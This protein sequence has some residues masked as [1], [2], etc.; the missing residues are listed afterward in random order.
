MDFLISF[1]NGQEGAITVSINKT[2]PVI[3]RLI[4]TPLSALES[5]IPQKV[6][7]LEAAVS[8]A[9]D[10]D[11]QQR[12]KYILAQ[13]ILY[14]YI[15]I[16]VMPE[17]SKIY[18]DFLRDG[19]SELRNNA[20]DTQDMQLQQLLNSVLDPIKGFTNLDVPLLEKLIRRLRPEETNPNLTH[21]ITIVLFMYTKTKGLTS[22]GPVVI[23]KVTLELIEGFDQPAFVVTPVFEIPLTTKNGAM[24]DHLFWKLI[25]AMRIQDHL[26]ERGDFTD[27][28][29]F[30]AQL[31]LPLD[32]MSLMVQMRQSAG[33]DQ[34]AGVPFINYV[35]M[36]MKQRALGFDY[37]LSC[38]ADARRILTRRLHQFCGIGGVSI[39]DRMYVAPFLR[40]IED[41]QVF[42]KE[43][44]RLFDILIDGEKDAA[45]QFTKALRY[46]ES[47]L[48]AA[49][50]AEGDEVDD[51]TTDS[52]DADG[53]GKKKKPVKKSP[54]KEKSVSPKKTPKTPAK[55][56]KDADEGTPSDQDDQGG[57]SSDP[58]AAPPP[59]EDDTVTS[60]DDSATL[61]DSDDTPANASQITDDNIDRTSDVGQ[62]AAAAKIK[63]FMPLALPTETFDDHLLRMAV[64]K[65]VCDLDQ[66]Q[67]PD[68]TPENLDTLKYWC[69]SWLFIASIGQTKK[70]LSRLELTGKLKELF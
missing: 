40:C 56:S 1:L 45:I 32:P 30:I 46:P 18:T 19:I 52:K 12:E 29:T 21:I 64:L 51:T 69:G 53:T 9:S 15:R 39:S 58:T 22:S 33:V 28:M 8:D 5:L 11:N 70:L 59:S 16:F 49:A 66:D 26:R 37:S 2:P 35:A 14:L 62:D 41:C 54:A 6:V 4:T 36:Y 55:A 61:D 20:I 3:L 34:R 43:D 31:A 27:I 23:S 67:A 25:Y 63:V 47:A 50:T 65:L 60:E 24:V 57:F 17:T 13:Y 38:L 10:V 44:D 42:S 68:I 48:E 7:A